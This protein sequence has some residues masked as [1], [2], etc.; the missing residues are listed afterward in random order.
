M[1]KIITLL[2]ALVM[3]LTVVLPATVETSYA[4][5]EFKVRTTMPGYDSTAGKKYYYTDDNVFYKHNL[6]PDRVYHSSYGGY[7]VGNC[8][9]YAYGRASEILGMPLNSEFRWSASQWWNTNKKG[10]YYPYG[11]KPKVG[12]IACYSTHVA[13]VE[14]VVDGKPYV[15]ESGWKVSKNKPTKASNLKFNYGKPWSSNPKGYIYIL[16]SPKAVDVDYTV[17]ITVSDLNMRTGPGTGYSRIGYVKKGTYDVV[18]ECGNWVQLE[19]NGYWVCLDY[20]TVI[21]KKEESVVEEGTA[22]DYKVKV[23][24]TNLNMRIGPGTKYDSKGYIK[25]GTYKVVKENNGWIKLEENGYWIA[26]NYAKKVSESTENN[27]TTDKTEDKTEA[28]KTETKEPAKNN[29]TLYTVKINTTALHM[30]TGPGTNY[31]S[32]GLVLRG[33]KYK[34]KDTKNGWGQ[35]NKNGYWI[36]LSYTIPVDAD[37][38][39]KVKVKKLNMRTGPG[40]KYKRKGYIKPGAYTITETKNGWGKVKSNGYWIKLSYTTKI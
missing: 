2:I 31:S 15:S 7:C 1:K 33:S 40:I 39:V 18:K 3:A 29:T 14:K 36:K 21:E 35:L 23:T 16:D 25:P 12:A 32:K 8:T 17:K 34:I 30:R 37:F 5:E 6:G 28:N 4:D 11:S 10:N 26:M 38:N 19:S 27:S 13:I 24:I 20:V 9:W 22:V